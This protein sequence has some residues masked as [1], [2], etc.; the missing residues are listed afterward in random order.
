MT[1]LKKMR[2][3]F[4]TVYLLREFDLPDAAKLDPTGLSVSYDDTFIACL[5]GKENLRVGVAKGQGTTADGF[6]LYEADN[7]FDYFPLKN[8]AKLLKPGGSN[9][10]AIEGHNANIKGYDFTIHHLLLIAN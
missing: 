5:N 4:T 3:K 2:G 1:R 10:L 9:V 8:I 6:T 7:K